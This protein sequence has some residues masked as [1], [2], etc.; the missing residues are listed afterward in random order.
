MKFLSGNRQLLSSTLFRFD[1]WTREAKEFRL[2]GLRERVD[3][4]CCKQERFEFLKGDRSV[5]A[6]DLCGRNAIHLGGCNGTKINFKLLAERV[7]KAGQVTYNE[8]MLRAVIG[9]FAITV[10]EDGRAIIDGTNDPSKA[11]SI[12]AKYIGV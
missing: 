10:F 12:Y 5:R 9:E 7:E 3:C 2:D 1:V 11:K 4:P 8:F 6:T